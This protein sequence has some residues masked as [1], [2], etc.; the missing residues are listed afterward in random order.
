MRRYLSS[1][2]PGRTAKLIL[3]FQGRKSPQ[4]RWFVSIGS[5]YSLPYAEIPNK[6]N[7]DGWIV[8]SFVWDYFLFKII[9]MENYLA[10]LLV[11]CGGLVFISFSFFFYIYL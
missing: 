1:F 9:S 11:A 3:T 8:L 5:N 10:P 2:I 4:I 6:I 7:I